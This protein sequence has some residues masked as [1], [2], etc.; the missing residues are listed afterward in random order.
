MEARALHRDG[1]LFWGRAH[2]TR[3]SGKDAKAWY[4]PGLIEDITQEKEA[5]AKISAY[6]ERLRALAT[7]LAMTEER[8]R[9]RLAAYLHDNIG[10]VLALLQ[11]KLGSLRQELRS[12]KMGADLDE[13][14]ALLSQIITATRSLTLEM[15]LS[16]LHELGFAPGVEWLG[17]EFQ[18]RYGLRIEVNCEP[19]PTSLDPFREALLFRSVRELLT[20]VAKH[21]RA[22]RVSIV[23]KKEDGQFV[24]QVADDGIGFEVSNLTE[25]AGFGLFS[26]AERVSN[27]GGKV[28]VTSIPGQGTKVIITMPL[29]N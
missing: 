13:A 8:E 6:Q 21:A 20:N 17:E 2:M 24:L 12:R 22:Q 26:I 27:Q 29:A 23:L 4:A 14:R 15:G 16:V 9:R 28:E 25:I 3:V 19:L 7:E 10:Q 18:T 1:H 11:I 5:L